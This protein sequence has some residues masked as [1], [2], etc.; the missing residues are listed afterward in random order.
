MPCMH[1]WQENRIQS[2][3]YSLQLPTHATKK[4]HVEYQ[5]ANDDIVQMWFAAAHRNT[6]KK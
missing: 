1:T 2:D 5:I 4:N 6:H 3:S